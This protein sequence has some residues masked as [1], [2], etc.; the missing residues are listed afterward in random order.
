[1][2]SHSQIV[3]DIRILATKS[4]ALEAPAQSI[5]IVNGPLIIVGQGPFPQV[6]TGL[7][8]IVSTATTTISEMQG[9]SPIALGTDSD[10]VSDAFYSVIYFHRYMWQSTNWSTVRYS[11]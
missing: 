9:R 6:I 11:P 2:A 7:M 1:M 8:D 10:A 5:T 3:S 4:Q